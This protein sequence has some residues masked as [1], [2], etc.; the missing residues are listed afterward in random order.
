MVRS[1]EVIE[2]SPQQQP[3]MLSLPTGD[4]MG[5]SVALTSN[6][7]FNSA[8]PLQAFSDRVRGRRMA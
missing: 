4:N 7:I 8:L 3:I 5:L 1:V 6:G 2:D